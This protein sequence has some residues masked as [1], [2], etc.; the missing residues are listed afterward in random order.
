MLPILLMRAIAMLRAGM[1]P[2]GAREIDAVRLDFDHRHRRRILLKTEAGRDLLLD[3]AETARLADGDALVLA[4]G[5]LVRVI[6]ADEDLLEIHAA[7]AILLRIAWHLG[8]R[9]LAVQFAGPALRIRADH[10]IAAMILGLG[11][12]IHELRAPFDP[13]SG[14]YAGAAPHSHDPGGFHDH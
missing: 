13:E 12:Q 11:G 10:V 8:N 4:G 9:H 3:L 5:G 1:W 6:A 7:P 14:A 2:E